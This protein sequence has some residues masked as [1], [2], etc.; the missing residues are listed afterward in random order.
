MKNK[1]L[2]KVL[3]SLILPLILTI[4]M[5]DKITVSAQNN[6]SEIVICAETGRV[7]HSKNEHIKMGMASTTKIVTCITVIDNYDL[8]KTIEIKKEW[9]GI[10][11]SS[12]YLKEG[13]QFTVKELLYGLMLRS[14]NDCAV[15]LAN[16]L[17]ESIE[18]FC[19]LM[20]TTALKAGAKNS[21]FDNPHGLDSENHYTT[22]YDLAL[23]TKYAMQNE[24]FCEIVSTK[25]ISIGSGESRRVL[26]NKNKMLTEYEGA[27]GVKTG[28]TK[29]C[30]RCLVSSS[31]KNGFKLISVVLN[32]PPMFER[33]KELLNQAYSD[34]K[35]KLI[36]SKDDC[37]GE[38]ITKSGEII[39]CYVKKHLFYPLK[40]GEEQFISTKIKAIDSKQIYNNFEQYC[41][42]IEISLKNH[43]IFLEKIYTI[44]V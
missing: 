15:A 8:D 12:I 31:D 20:V 37:V 2:K 24:I 17:S 13:E 1:F 38:V 19:K 28:Y 22:A 35:R 39:P 18:N 7:L 5:F 4:F 40:D 36:I 3:I 30:G 14:G 29:K 11:G 27:T 33:S 26:I 42:S 6:S 21:N 25:K 10:E 16:A 23:I 9:T 44:L 41:G 43:L 34:Y 32:C